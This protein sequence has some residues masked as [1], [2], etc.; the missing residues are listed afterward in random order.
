MSA[1]V[2]RLTAL[3]VDNPICLRCIAAA[4]SM[5]AET[6]QIAL[7]VLGHAID[8]HEAAGRCPHCGVPDTVYWIERP[9]IAR[10]G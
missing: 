3:I 5:S 8:V 7:T 1:W 9:D 10:P 6:A 2:L 4:A